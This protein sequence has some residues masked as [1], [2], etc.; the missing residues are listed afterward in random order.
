MS[1]ILVLG[2]GMVGMTTA[3]ELQSRGHRV[4]VVDR[5]PAG[6]ETSFGNAGLIQ[7]EAAEPYAMPRSLPELRDLLLGRSNDVLWSPAGVWG[8]MPA[9]WQYFRNSHPVR[10]LALSR[11]HAQLIATASRDQERWIA[12]SKAQDLI[13]KTG[14]ISIFDDARSFDRA[15]ADLSR[16]KDLYDIA[17]TPMDGARFCAM[18]PSYLRPPAG[19]IH[20]QD[21]WSCSDPGG[22]VAR[23]A[24][25]FQQQGGALVTGDASSLQRRGDRWDVQTAA[26]VIAAEQAVIAL[27]P[28]SP[29]LLRRLGYRVRMIRKQG[30]HRMY[31]TPVPL[32]RPV[33]HTRYS[34]VLSSM[35]G[36]TRMTCGVALHGR[37]RRPDLRQLDRAAAGLATEIDLGIP[38]ADAP[39]HGTRPFMPDMLPMLGAA[40]R[41]DRLWFNF[42]HGHQGFTLGATTARHLADMV[43][44]R[45]R[46]GG[47]AETWLEALTP[48]ARPKV[49]A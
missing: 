3:L 45:V 12:A 11:P 24:A 19:A 26:G 44:G 42:G 2:A 49:I 30:A 35:R 23:Y 13:A 16:L 4:T 18:E 31:D 14:Y 21:T 20:W 6:Q 36:G 27:G 22:L 17:A 32:R 29:D 15:A 7:S 8:Q 46:P 40:P 10:H 9:L 25:L 43:D 33:F 1:E 5:K 41:H 28:W 38:T 34:V 37:A 48:A 39:W 47:G